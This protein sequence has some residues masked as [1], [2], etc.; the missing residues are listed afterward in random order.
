M[1]ISIDVAKAFDKIQY[2]YIIKTQ[3]R[4]TKE[5]LQLDEDYLLNFHN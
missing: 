5:F 2:I 3:T 4:K 1:A